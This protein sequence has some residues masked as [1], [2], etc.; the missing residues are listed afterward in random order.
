MNLIILTKYVPPK[1][2]SP[3]DV[4]MTPYG[5]FPQL[6]E[7]EKPVLKEDEVFVKIIQSCIAIVDSN[8]VTFTSGKEIL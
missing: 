1:V 3:R 7:V 2:L 4:Q 6:K 5:G 8:L